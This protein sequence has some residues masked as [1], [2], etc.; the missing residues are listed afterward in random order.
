M[1]Q[2]KAIIFK[3]VP[4]GL[5]VPGKHL[6]VE[7]REFD[8]E[9][10]PPAGGITT[11]NFYASF[12]PYQRGRMREPNTKSYSPP[13]QL[14]API[15]SAAVAK[16]L[17]SDCPK[18]K[19]GD[20]IS[21]GT[22]T[23]EYSSLPKQ[24]AEGCKKIENPYNL[25]PMYYI[26]PLGMPGLT[27]YAS[28][29]DIGKPVKGETIFIS[30]ASGAVGQLVGQFAK[31]EGLRVIGSVGSDEKL[32]YITKEL[33]FDGG[34]NYKK[35]KPA[36]ALARLAPN[37]VDIY[38]ENVGGEQLEAAL[39]AMNDFGRIV[40][41][42]MVSQYNTPM[43]ERYGIKNLFLVVS[44][45][46]TMRGFIVWDQNMGPV[47][48]KERDEKVSKWLH[49]GSIKAKLSVTDGI[50]NGPKAFVGML[51]GK[52]FGK[53]VLKIA[54]LEKVSIDDFSLCICTDPSLVSII[55]TLSTISA[56]HGRQGTKS[57]HK[58]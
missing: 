15:S 9:Q 20:L 17:K 21:G 51:E 13:Y 38:F 7:S 50:D 35:E 4:S 25:D 56:I 45:R 28:L 19:A 16:V 43:P 52:N 58:G 27:A 8:L 53:A 34:F 40:A 3:E 22:T 33:N 24:Y 37:G 1:V 57:H 18:F 54:D 26:G 47:Y 30:A 55:T 6:V 49:E 10:A 14:G 48:A 46:I 44:K 42:G 32:E 12:D 39:D 36:D 5:P 23:E 29:H 11:K 2:N 41:C 31:R